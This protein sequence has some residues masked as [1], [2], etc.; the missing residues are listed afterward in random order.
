LRTL[1]D[2]RV[3]PVGNYASLALILMIFGVMVFKP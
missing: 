2:D 3:S 1:L